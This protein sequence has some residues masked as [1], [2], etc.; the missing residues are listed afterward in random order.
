MS[1]AKNGKKLSLHKETLV[2]LSD[3]SLSQAAGGNGD[4]A[5]IICVFSV[6]IICGDS[7][8]CSVL[9]GACDNEN[10]SGGN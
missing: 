5:G 7:V 9:A 6:L 8:V 4:T 10:G 3:E 2:N 1:D